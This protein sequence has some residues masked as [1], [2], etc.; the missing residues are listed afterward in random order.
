MNG[1]LRVGNLFGIPFYVN[2]SWFLVLGLVTWSY[3]SGLAA[4][5]PELGV[6]AWGLGLVTALLLFASVLAHELGHSFVAMAQGIEVKSITLFIFGGLASLG[7]ES[8]TPGGSFRVAIAGP[9]VSFA[10]FGLFTAVNLLVDLPNSLAAIVALL[11]Y[12]NLALGAFNLIPGL[13][14]DGGNVLKSIVW[15]ITGKPYKGVAFASRVGQFF[16]WVGVALGILSVL[17]LSNVGSIWTLLIGWFLLQNAGRSA[18]SATVQEKLSGLTAGDAVD[19]NSPIISA[20]S[21]LREFANDYIIGNEKNWQ[22]F[23]VTDENGQLIGEI[24]VDSMK[25]IPTNDWWDVQV[26]DLMQ[27]TDQIDT[28]FSDKPLLEVIGLL[29]ERKLPA[30]AVIRDNGV[31]VGLLE[32]ASIIQLL[33]K[34]AEA[35]AA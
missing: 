34:K 11:S 30:L 35:E 19:P 6:A 22:K 24:S 9:L 7:E 18:Q 4:Q 3:G 17:G 12:I 27:P 29:E 10:L 2:P 20:S 5:F 15:K 14:L 28:V 1:N 31:L 32:K 16:G 13:P 25:T 8:K 33:Q 21:S 23:L 26:K